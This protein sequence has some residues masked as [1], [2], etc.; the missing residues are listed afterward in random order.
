MQ[1]L[2]QMEEEMGKR[3]VSP[4]QLKDLSGLLRL[5]SVLPR[6]FRETTIDGCGIRRV[7][8]RAEEFQNEIVGLIMRYSDSENLEEH[9]NLIFA[10]EIAL[11]ENNWP[12]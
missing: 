1:L 12:A 3:H 10:D 8:L 4:A 5:R 9:I 6:L 7:T 2:T 11:I